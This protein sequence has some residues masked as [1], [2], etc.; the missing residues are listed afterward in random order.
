[1]FS[2]ILVALLLFFIIKRFFTKVSLLKNI[3]LSVLIAGSLFILHQVY[4][5][6]NAESCND[7]R[8]SIKCLEGNWSYTDKSGRHWNAKINFND[9]SKSSSDISGVIKLT[10]DYNDDSKEKIY[11]NG[12]FEIDYLT[13]IYGKNLPTIVPKKGG[14]GII[15]VQNDALP[16]YQVRIADV[17]SE[18]F[19]DGM[20]KY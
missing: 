10:Y 1:M 12:E 11:Y 18:M 7:V 9:I 8:G 13:D 15:I 16:G 20:Y 5:N 3:G 17:Y 19:G 4:D 6:Y 2:S 14:K